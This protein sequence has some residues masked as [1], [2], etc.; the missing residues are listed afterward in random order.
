MKDP[1][2]EDAYLKAN[3]VAWDEVAPI[4]ARHNQARLLEHV[5]KSGF[6]VLDET[7][8]AHL[9]RLGI[10]G[11]SVAQVCCNNGIELLSCKA[12][13]AA[14]CVGFD[15]AQGFVD[16]GRELARAAGL[17][18][19]FVR[20]EAHAIPRE[21]QRCF[22]IV[23]ITIGVL[24]W[25][26]DI[27]RFFAETARLLAPDGVIFIYE[28]HS[29]LAMLEPGK[30]DDPI[31]W[32]LSYFRQE[33]YIDSSGLDYYGDESYEAT[34][35]ASFSHKMSDIVMGGINTGLHLE[36]FEELPKHISNAW[37]NV[38]QSGIGLPMSFVMVFRNGSG[39][40]D[41]NSP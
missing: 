14:R 3:L 26:P 16:Q 31:T 38:E 27:D 22:D 8:T 21:Y 35:N 40:Q 20:S 12:L 37:W 2:I 15:G 13:G 36:F 17:D 32:E 39:P 30:A 9:I 19:E 4:H 29:I 1:Q 7:A 11:K 34:P 25:M 23:V 10:R 33:A 6:S 24:S 18:L 28:H 5:R 41:K